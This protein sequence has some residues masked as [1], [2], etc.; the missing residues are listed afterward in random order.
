MLL[1]TYIGDFHMDAIFQL[2][3]KL[4]RRVML[5]PVTWA[6]NICKILTS[7]HPFTVNGTFCTTTSNDR[8]FL[9]LTLCSMSCHLQFRIWHSNT[10]VV[11][12]FFNGQFNNNVGSR[13]SCRLFWLKTHQNKSSYASWVWKHIPP[14]LVI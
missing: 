4:L 13:T 2:L 1:K 10:Y 9:L 5:D 11:D 8:E 12:P 6:G 7:C 14:Y 3:F